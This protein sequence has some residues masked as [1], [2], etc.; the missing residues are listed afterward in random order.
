MCQTP[1]KVQTTDNRHSRGR[2][3]EQVAGYR[4]TGEERPGPENVSVDGA[5]E[6]CWPKG[7]DEY[8]EYCK[9]NESPFDLSEDGPPALFDPV[10]KTH[11]GK[12]KA[13]TDIIHGAM[14]YNPLVSLVIC[15]KARNRGTYS[16]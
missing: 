4:D 14:I 1:S 12:R 16:G 11:E 7:K 5:C 10:S 2:D 3:H 6:H 8:M 13:H 15:S 9:E